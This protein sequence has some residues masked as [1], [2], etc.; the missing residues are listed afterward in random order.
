MQKIKDVKNLQKTAN[1]FC[2]E[3]IQY[4]DKI[5]PTEYYLIKNCKEV[6]KEL[7]NFSSTANTPNYDSLS[8]NID[9]L[10]VKAIVK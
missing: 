2:Q 10:T 9:H 5:K 1:P 4:S 3:K 6:T 7:K 8:E